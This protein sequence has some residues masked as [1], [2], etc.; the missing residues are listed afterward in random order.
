MNNETARR[1]LYNFEHETAWDHTAPG[2]PIEISGDSLVVCN[3][4][5]GL[6]ACTTD[7][8]SKTI[9]DIQ[10]TLWAWSTSFDVQLLAPLEGL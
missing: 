3:W 2:V 4:I 9:A 5:N 7:V 8:Y 6:Y 10:N 1:L